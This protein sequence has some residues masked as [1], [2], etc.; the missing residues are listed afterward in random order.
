M[1][2]FIRVF[3]NEMVFLFSAAALALCVPTF[4]AFL[5]LACWLPVRSSWVG[6]GLA[7]SGRAAL[8]QGSFWLFFWV[9]SLAPE[10]VTWILPKC[11]KTNGF[12]AIYAQRAA[13]RIVACEPLCSESSCFLECFC[14]F[15]GHLLVQNELVGAE[16]GVSFGVSTVLFRAFCGFFL[17]ALDWVVSWLAP[18]WPDLDGGSL[19]PG[20]SFESF[21]GPSVA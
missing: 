4:G 8:D 18:L 15:G 16:L 11:T 3:S 17:G 9:A 10:M 19:W 12:G 21:F 2:F 14:N 7:G 1:R 13:R 6:F 20:V 5:F